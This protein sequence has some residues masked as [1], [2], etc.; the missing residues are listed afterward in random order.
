MLNTEKLKELME[1]TGYSYDELESEPGNLR[2]FTEAWTCSF[3]C[4]AD[5]YRWLNGVMFDDPDITDDIEEG[6]KDAGNPVRMQ[7]TMISITTGDSRTVTVN[8]PSDEEDLKLL[9]QS[10]RLEWAI[11]DCNGPLKL[12]GTENIFLLNRLFQEFETTPDEEFIILNNLIQEPDYIA[13]KLRKGFLYINFTEWTKNW[14]YPDIHSDMDKGR[15]LYEH[16]YMVPKALRKLDRESYDE[17]GDWIRWDRLWE[18]AESDGWQVVSIDA[19]GERTSYLVDIYE[20]WQPVSVDE[21]E[22][23]N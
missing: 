15:V 4:W 1:M 13:K 18:E 5:V 16:G 10:D 14:S 9:L 23:K 2:F 3:T 22:G 7:V 19:D 8:L 17:W 12:Q 20:G 21:D 11:A 6:L